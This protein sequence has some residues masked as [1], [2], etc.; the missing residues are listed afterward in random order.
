[1]RNYCAI[2]RLTKISLPK[3]PKLVLKKRKISSRHC[4]KIVPGQNNPELQNIPRQ[5]N[6]RQNCPK[7]TDKTVPNKIVP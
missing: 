2:R 5:N 6:P 7:K 3:K 4:A 1:M